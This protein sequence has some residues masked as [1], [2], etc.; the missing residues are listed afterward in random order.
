[1]FCKKC[2]R[3]MKEGDMFC[4]ECGEPV[5][6]SRDN[7]KQR[8][9]Y[10]PG[11]SSPSFDLS[12]SQIL[13]LIKI[14]LFKPLS[15]FSEFKGKETVKTSI[16]LILGLPFLYGI[17]NIIYSSAIVSS[18]FSGIKKI[19]D[20]LANANIISFQEAIEAKTQLAMSTEFLTF[21]NQIENMIDNKK[22]FLNGFLQIFIIII[23]TIIILEMLNMLMLK[24]KIKAIDILFISSASYIPLLLSLIVASLASLVSILLGVFIMIFGYV[25]SFITL[26]SGIKQF[27]DEKND[28]IFA[29]MTITFVI[30]SVIGTIIITKSFEDSLLTIKNFFTS[31]ERFI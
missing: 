3:E 17:I 28:K 29:V 15:F 12:N 2:G 30:V 16:A 27:S 6:E 18:F 8:T 21:R 9:S 24:S 13:K 31:L 25:L 4:G 7:R 10:E 5:A 14:Y 1:M 23:V 11:P 19:P 22:I 20:I 26:Y